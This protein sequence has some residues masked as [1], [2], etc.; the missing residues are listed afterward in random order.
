MGDICCWVLVAETKKFFLLEVVSVTLHYFW[1][2][3][4]SLLVRKLIVIYA[5][6]LCLCLGENH[7][8]GQDSK[9][10]FEQPF[11]SRNKLWSK[12]K[13]YQISRFWDLFIR[14]CCCILSVVQ[15]SAKPHNTQ[16]S[17]WARIYVLRNVQFSTNKQ[18]KQNSRLVFSLR[19]S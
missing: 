12:V 1:L 9:D 10:Q 5:P 11:C 18:I 14:V 7:K 8:T 13:N 16:N 4:F 3:L 19:R 6:F 2:L 15:T 17:K